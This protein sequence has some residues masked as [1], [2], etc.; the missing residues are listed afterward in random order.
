MSTEEKITDD[1]EFM[2]TDDMG[3]FTLPREGK[4]SDGNGVLMEF[5]G[6]IKECGAEGLSLGFELAWCEDDSA[7]T[8]IYAKTTTSQGMTRIVGIGTHSGVFD[9]I[10]A[11]RKAKGKQGIRTETGAVR[12]KVL[13]DPKFQAQL[14]KEIVGCKVLCD[15]THKPAEAY[16]DKKTGETKPGY[17]KAEVGR[18]APAPKGAKAVVAE[19]EKAAAGS[20]NEDWE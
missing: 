9:K 19:G 12:G 6:E 11:A 8:S 7:K 2:P 15:I 3:G 16:E 10:D 20:D 14:R 18:I 5:T 17:P 1:M 4:I 13:K